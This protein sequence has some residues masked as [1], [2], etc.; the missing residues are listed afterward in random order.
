MQSP[1]AKGKE[2]L[3]DM[4]LVTSRY[5]DFIMARVY[6]HNTLTTLAQYATVPIINGL[7]NFSHP[8]QVIG[9]LVTIKEHK[10]RLRNLKLAYV[11]DGNN[12]VTHSLL[13][14]CS[15]VGMNI[16]IGHPKG[17]SPQQK[18]VEHAR[19][20]A[21]KLGSK[22]ILT[23]NPK[24]AVE[25]ADIIYTDSWMSYH[26]PKSKQKTRERILKSFQVNQTLLSHAK[27]DVSF[28]HCLPA[29]RGKEVT[30]DVLYGKKSI[31]LDQAENRMHAEKA[32]LLFLSR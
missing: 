20:T 18:V 10:G 26:I 8:C 25:D 27:R 23:N 19:H 24:E 15:M 2:S 9:D 29:I 16:A 14:G 4:A 12:N 11:G 13:F 32:I 21:D 1:L 17:F 30:A 28:M 31:V 6:E 7:S 22:V 5:V 3:R